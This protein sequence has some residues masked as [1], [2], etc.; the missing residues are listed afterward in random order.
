V[1]SIFVETVHAI[2]KKIPKIQYASG[3]DKCRKDFLRYSTGT[4]VSGCGEPKTGV[5]TAFRPVKAEFN[6]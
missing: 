3:L 1:D 2:Q 6:Q 5:G 4:Q